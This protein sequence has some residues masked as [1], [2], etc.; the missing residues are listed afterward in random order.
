MKKHFLIGTILAFISFSSCDYLDIMPPNVATLED[1]F[2]NETEAQKALYTVYSYM[3]KFSDCRR[4]VD[5]YP[6]D[7]FVHLLDNY[8]FPSL[9]IYSGENSSSQP[10]ANFWSHF[11]AWRINCPLYEGIR[12]GY[13][14]IDKVDEVPG[15]SPEKAAQW[16][17][18]A[19]FLIA[20]YHA[21]LLRYYGP[22]VLV[23][24]L[25]PMDAPSDEIF[26]YRSPYDECVE[27]ITKRL[28]EVA[29]E[30]PETLSTSNYG[31]PTK[32]AAKAVK[33]RLLLYAASPLFNGNSEFYADFKDK[34]GRNLISLDYDKEKWNKAMVAAEDAINFAVASGHSLYAHM[35]AVN[36]DF[37]Q[38]VNNA[39]YTMVQPWNSE[40]I[41]GYTGWNEDM[42]HENSIQ[43]QAAPRLWNAAANAPMGGLPY[44]THA[45]T[46]TAASFLFTANGLPIDADPDFNY[47]QRYSHFEVVDGEQVAAFNLG[48]EPRY[49][50]YIGYDRGYYEI[51]ADTIRLK[52]RYKEMHGRTQTGVDYSASGFLLKKGIHPETMFE[53]KDKR[54]LK[55]YPFPL[56]R[57]GELYLN[58]IEAYVEYYGKLDG[59]ALV[60]FNELRAKNGLPKWE[61]VKGKATRPIS[62]IEI[63]R[64]ERTNELLFEG[65][66]F[67][68]VR[69]WKETFHYPNESTL[70]LSTA[71]TV[72]TRFWREETTKEPYS[73][74][75]TRKDYLQPIYSEDININPNLVQN[76]GY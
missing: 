45:P 48:R 67:H 26:L 10:T 28:D 51:N 52:M 50:A 66:R 65:H 42:N 74:L 57:L 24:K 11:N 22:I 40:L 16:K 13:L 20:Y 73:R 9:N 21:L 43:V 5:F 63:V 61:D 58:Y 14:F 29:A 36:N 31:K 12:W 2:R 8:W 1:A 39:R 76:P 56:A 32:A 33:S 19:R 34:K 25:I 62:D 6:T 38:A 53:S 60:L 27:W 71:Q 41:W 18:E 3:P 70:K 30:L 68:D 64:A 37:Q 72:V 47:E 69:R 15:I 35:P 4:N 17:T 23:D 75:F 46:L 7:E 55:K 44:Q 54:T 59:K 49:Y